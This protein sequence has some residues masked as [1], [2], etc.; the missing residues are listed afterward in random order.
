MEAAPGKAVPEVWG[1][2]LVQPSGK[3]AAGPSVAVPEGDAGH[4]KLAC[5]EI[6]KI[7]PKPQCPENI[8][9]DFLCPEETA[10]WLAG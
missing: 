2:L 1:V 10:R 3:E 9:K 4:T 5:T 6:P 8:S 7:L